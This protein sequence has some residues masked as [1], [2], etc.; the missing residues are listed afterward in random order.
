MSRREESDTKVRV[1]LNTRYAHPNEVVLAIQH[2]LDIK[3]DEVS[4]P[5]DELSGNFN[6][7]KVLNDFFPDGEHLYN[8]FST[9]AYTLNGM[10][11]ECFGAY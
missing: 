8:M 6:P 11:R 2:I 9:S 4:D 1:T 3:Q 7:V 10:Y 5:F